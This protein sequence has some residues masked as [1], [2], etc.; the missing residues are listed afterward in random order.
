LKNLTSNF[1]VVA[2]AILIAVL[3][4]VTLDQLAKKFTKKN[5]AT[6]Q[7]YV[8]SSE[9]AQ[10]VY[11]E[12]SKALPSV[13]NL[14]TEKIE[15]IDLTEENSVTMDQVFTDESVNVVMRQL[16]K[17][18]DNL[19]KEKVITLVLKSP[20]GSVDAGNEL[21]S[22]AK[23]LPQK[24][25]TLSIFS[26]SMS[27]QTS[28]NLGERLVLPHSTVMSH[29]AKFGI[30]GEAP[31]EMF[32]KLKY[33]MSSIDELEQIAAARMQMTFDDYRKLVADEYWVYGN[34]A[35]K[36]RAA[37]RLVLA[38]CS[39]EMTEGTKTL[40]IDTMFGVFKVEVSKCPLIPGI[41]SIKSPT[42]SVTQEQLNY[43]K[44]MITNKKQFVE[45]Y[46][47]TMKWEQFQKVF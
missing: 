1:V 4:P 44:K 43:V 22:F 15:I 11:L 35:V 36:D 42:D 16:Q 2:L 21:I 26:A 29:R 14:K 33:I 13:S 31:G 6:A 32:S 18:S 28:Q 25:R 47:L 46:V 20:G 23:A 40:E 3:V 5:E 10:P 17:L 9:A 34:N 45:D 19:P 8:L 37:D 39:K 12:A 27:F 30:S 7:V 38:R 24:V 41:M